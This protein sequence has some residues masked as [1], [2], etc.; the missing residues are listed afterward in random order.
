MTAVDGW[1]FDH[2]SPAAMLI[3]EAALGA[4]FIVLILAALKF[5]GYF[6]AQALLKTQG[7]DALKLIPVAGD[8]AME[9]TAI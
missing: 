5:A 6:C 1:V 3:T 7:I 2:Y 4:I 8:R 9:S